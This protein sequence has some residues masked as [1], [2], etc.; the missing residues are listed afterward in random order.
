MVYSV[1]STF[2]QRDID[3]LNNLGYLV[4]CIASPP[5]TTLFPFLWNRI[6]ELF[7]AM[8]YF[9]KSETLLC[10][11]S[12]Y[13][14]FIPLLVARVMAKESIVVVGGYDAVSLPKLKY[15][16]FYKNNMRRRI[17]CWNYRLTKQIW[18]V[19]RSLKD[20]CPTARRQNGSQSGLVHFMPDLATPIIEVPTGY[21]P[22][23]WRVEG[24]KVPKTVITVASIADLRGWHR[25][26]IPLFIEL[27]KAIPEFTFTLAGLTLQGETIENLPRK[28]TLFSRQTPKELRQL[29]SQHRFY[30]QGSQ[31]EGLPNV[32]CEAMLCECIPIGNAIFGI[33]EV[34]GTTGLTF[35][36]VMDFETIKSFLRSPNPT[37][38]KAARARIV[39]HYTAERRQ[40]TV[41][42]LLLSSKNR[43]R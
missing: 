27:A 25:K 9:N 37:G 24:K 33:P 43:Q 13:H 22:G 19:H 34:I 14:A 4:R 1:K 41:E 26:G 23:F 18:V 2:V 3:M 11:F 35:D 40:R 21:D 28:P 8:A 10:W 39:K 5:Y 29:Y 17:A 36:G 16:I 7:L 38:G 32:L 15:G 31:V 12:D 20:G 6:K 30:F 42:Q